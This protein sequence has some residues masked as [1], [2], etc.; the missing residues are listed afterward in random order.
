MTLQRRPKPLITPRDIPALRA[1]LHD[2]SSVFNPGAVRWRDREVLLLRVQT[3]GRTT[4][5]LPAELRE[6]ERVEIVGAPV[7]IEGLD[8][9]HLSVQPAQPKAAQR[10]RLSVPSALIKP[11]A[12]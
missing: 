10:R 4:V 6:G 3:R 1:D 11:H 8:G 12:A 2:V 7:E 5:L 9:V